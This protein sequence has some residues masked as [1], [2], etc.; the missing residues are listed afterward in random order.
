MTFLS[1][2]PSEIATDFVR[3]R[4]GFRVVSTA[5]GIRAVRAEIPDCPLS[6][7]ELANLIAPRLL[8]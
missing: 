6:D 8:P 2:R 3:S 7:H 5:D 1:R 4:S